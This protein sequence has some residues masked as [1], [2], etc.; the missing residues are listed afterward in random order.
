MINTEKLDA[1]ISGLRTRL[2]AGLLATDV[3]ER[4]SQI[5]LANYNGQPAGVDMMN[6][7]MRS[8]EDALTG[9]GF[10]T[11][12]QYVVMEMETDK[13]VLIVKHGSD[14]LQG[15]LLDTRYANMGVVLSVGRRT[16]LQGVQQAR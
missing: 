14:L 3:W 1:M 9:S 10:P 8:V 12:N 4:G 5:S 2:G 7:L 6:G 16:C 15:L 11:I 13:A